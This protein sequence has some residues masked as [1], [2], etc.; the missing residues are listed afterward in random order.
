MHG[1]LG[2]GASSAASGRL[3]EGWDNRKKAP[4]GAASTVPALKY[5]LLN[6]R[7]LQTDDISAGSIGP[8]YDRTC[9]GLNI[10]RLLTFCLLFLKMWRNISL[11]I[12]SF[13]KVYLMSYLV[14]LRIGKLY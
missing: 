14:S 3:G 1:E 11:R 9:L 2:P 7:S 5:G 12:D 8:D 10:M 4:A 13:A 6:G